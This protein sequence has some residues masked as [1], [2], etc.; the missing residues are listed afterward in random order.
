MDVYEVR[1]ELRRMNK[2]DLFRLASNQKISRCLISGGACV[3][4][5]HYQGFN[6]CISEILEQSC[7][8][9][10]S[11]KL[12][13][14]YEDLQID[15]P[16]PLMERSGMSPLQKEERAVVFKVYCRDDFTRS[17][18]LLGKVIERRIKERGNNLNDLLLKAIKEYSDC[19]ADPSTI[20]LLSP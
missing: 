8:V 18:V 13:D 1:S 3:F 10:R 9:E 15:D 19:A 2:G 11:E 12:E 14:C 6:F 5:L 7:Q 17:M 4:Y 20:F 16:L